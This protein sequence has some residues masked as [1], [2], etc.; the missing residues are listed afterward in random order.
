MP[1]RR[2]R[3]RLPSPL[4]QLIPVLAALPLVQP[5]P[6]GAAD[7]AARLEALRARI[8]E[9]EAE[10]KATESELDGLQLELRRREQAMAEA[11]RSLRDLE[12]R[13]AGAAANLA[14]LE[15][16]REERGAELGKHRGQL[17]EQ[18]RAAH[19]LSRQSYLKLLLNQ[20]DP[21]RLSRALV[22]YDYFNRSRLERIDALAARLQSLEELEQSIRQEADGL[23]RLRADQLNQVQA[24]AEHRDARESLVA[25]LQSRLQE[26]GVELQRLKEDET[27]LASLLKQLH[28][29]LHQSAPAAVPAAAGFPELRGR[30]PRPVAG[31]LTEA[32]GA[33]RLDGAMTSPG[34]FIEAPPGT[35]VQA[36]APGR[37]AFA[38]WF[39][40]LG[41]LLI[42]DH[43][44]GY[45]S[46]YGHN[47]TLLKAAGEPV[48][49]GE[50][51]AT[52]GASGGQ[53]R[54]GL[55]FELRHLGRPQDPV[56]WW[57]RP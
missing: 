27:R 30:L 8:A 45:M 13:I 46:L 18:I 7:E 55:Y 2:H 48:V 23:Q 33:A 29:A 25:R 44:D 54:S 50:T 28:S 22:Y 31:T 17:A 26:Q 43:G 42:I 34:V 40:H 20:E 11:S 6:A 3:N 57:R 36:V 47:E 35:A 21:A 41:L 53:S 19:V 52:V 9:V 14:E 38:D 49:A 16:E 24:L 56:A 10:V 5:L 37:V 51:V 12:V 1:H 39:R 15:A 32:F 4:R